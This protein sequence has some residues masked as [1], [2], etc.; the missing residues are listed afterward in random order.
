MKTISQGVNLFTHT[1]TTVRAINIELKNGPINENL[2]RFKNMYPIYYKNII[3]KYQQKQT[4]SLKV[5]IKVVFKSYIYI[6]TLDF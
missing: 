4:F 5:V 2:I 6:L 3:I 1:P